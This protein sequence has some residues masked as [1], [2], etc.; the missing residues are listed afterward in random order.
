MENDVPTEP[1]NDL[2]PVAGLPLLAARPPLQTGGLRLVRCLA[3]LFRPIVI[4]WRVF[5]QKTLES[6]VNEKLDELKTC[7]KREDLQRLLG[8][9][10]YVVDGA[11][12]GTED[13]PDLIECYESEGC[14]IDL[15]F[16]D[17]RLVNTSGFVKPTLW[18]V[19]LAGRR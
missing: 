4:I 16:K 19:A 13:R 12:C 10:R 8:E 6:R 17:N 2:A 14:C 1:H 7:R 18:D 9:P 5:S 15:W 11:V 3:G